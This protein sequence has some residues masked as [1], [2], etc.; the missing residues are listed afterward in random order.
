MCMDLIVN[1]LLKKTVN[2]FELMEISESIYEGVV[3]NSCKKPTREDANCAGII[4]KMI[5]E[6]TLS[7][8]YSGVSRFSGKRIKIYVDHTKDRS[9]I[10]CLIH[11][12]VHLSCGFKVLG[13]FGSKY[14][15]SIPTKNHRQGPTTKRKFCI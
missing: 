11:V 8:T 10:T 4:R 12:P 2:M 9:K 3:E 15:K 7:N 13:D 5:V 6:A 1:P 14:Y